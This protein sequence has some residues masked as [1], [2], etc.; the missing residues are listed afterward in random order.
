MRP[1]FFRGVVTVVSKLLNAVRP[2]VAFFGQKDGEHGEGLVDGDQD[3]GGTNCEGG[4]W[5]GH[6]Q[7]QCVFEL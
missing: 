3:C 6:E 7:S 1:H 2:D 5:S 4:G